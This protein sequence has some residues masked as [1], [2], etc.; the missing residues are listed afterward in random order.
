MGLEAD[1]MCGQSQRQ[2]LKLYTLCSNERSFKKIRRE[3]KIATKKVSIS[4]LL[5]SSLAETR[6][7][8]PK[9]VD[10]IRYVMAPL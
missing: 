3:K 2:R 8:L 5:H 6:L 4:F 1:L 7:Y 10:S 9:N